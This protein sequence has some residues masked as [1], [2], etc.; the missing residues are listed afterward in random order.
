MKREYEKENTEEIKV[1]NMQPGLFHYLRE[2][3]LRAFYF[4]ITNI[5]TLKKK[6]NYERETQKMNKKVETQ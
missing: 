1:E 5:Q 6:R 4:N 2:L 3:V